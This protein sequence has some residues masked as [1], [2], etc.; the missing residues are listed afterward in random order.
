MIYND[1]AKDIKC[2]TSKFLSFCKV[3]QLHYNTD[4]AGSISL[5]LYAIQ[6]NGMAPLKWCW[7]LILLNEILITLRKQI[8]NDE[9]LNH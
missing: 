8:K 5:M 3:H 9:L 4:N 6:M 2:W 1:G 7:K